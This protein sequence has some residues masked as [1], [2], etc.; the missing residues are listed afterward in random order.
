M[1]KADEKKLSNSDQKI[2]DPEKGIQIEICE[3]ED[4][5][6][7]TKDPKKLRPPST[8]KKTNVRKC[9]ISFK[10]SHCRIISK[11]IYNLAIIFNMILMINLYY[12]I[13]FVSQYI[14]RPLLAPNGTLQVDKND[15]S[16]YQVDKLIAKHI[17]VENGNFSNDLQANQLYINSNI[18]NQGNLYN[19]GELETQGNILV[20]GN[21]ENEGNIVVKGNMENQGSVTIYSDLTVDNQLNAADLSISN[22]LNVQSDITTSNLKTNTLESRSISLEENAV[23]NGNITVIGDSQFASNL[24]TNT[25]EVDSSS[26]LNQLS[27]NGGLNVTGQTILNGDLTTDSIDTKH[28]NSNNISTNIA[29]ANNIEVVYSITGQDVVATSL[30]GNTLNRCSQGSC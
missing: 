18:H 28:M 6:S 9:R 30:F 26:N 5:G 10:P 15:Q 3:I 1:N 7:K 8:I 23:V 29:K 17:E 2:E 14:P 4:N 16:I 11:T 13:P 27:I 24:K 22:N 19:K 25:L 12:D 21:M 20:K